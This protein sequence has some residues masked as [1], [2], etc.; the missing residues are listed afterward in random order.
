M[1]TWSG[2][3]SNHKKKMLQIMSVLNF[4]S[5][6]EYYFFAVVPKNVYIFQHLR[7]SYPLPLFRWPVRN[8]YENIFAK[9]VFSSRPCLEI[10]PLWHFS[11]LVQNL[12]CPPFEKVILVLHF[13][14]VSRS[15]GWY[16]KNICLNSVTFLSVGHEVIILLE[17]LLQVSEWQENPYFLQF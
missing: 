2:M 4:T 16:M 8:S 3:S 13:L 14:S 9:K 17:A 6:Y 1:D 5:I 11:V 10:S 12:E 15:L 7:L